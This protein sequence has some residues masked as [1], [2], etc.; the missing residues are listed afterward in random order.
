MAE[1]VLY[2]L[3][4]LQLAI[5]GG[6]FLWGAPHVRRSQVAAPAPPGPFPPVTVIV[7]VTGDAPL[8]RRCL[9][10]LLTNDYPDF[11]VIFVTRDE[12]DPAVAVIGEL[13]ARH[14][15]GRHVV[16]GPARRCG[17]KNHN[18]LAG[19]AAADPATDILVFC[20]ATHVAPPGFLGRL[21]R[22]LAAGEAVL[23]TGFHRIIPQDYRVG[24]LGMLMIV[25]CLHLLHGNRFI[26]QPWGGAT[27]I[28]RRVFQD[29]GVARVWAENI[30][31]DVSMAM[32]L[33]KDGIRV[34]AVGEAILETPLAG[35][36]VAHWA[37]WLVRQLLYL[38]FCAP[39]LWLGALVVV[40]ALVVPPLW[41]LGA[42]LG[43][44]GGWVSPGTA[45]PGWLYLLVLTALGA[46]YRTLAP[47][48]I[49]WPR[50]LLAYYATLMVLPWCYLRTWGTDIMA[51]RGIS[52][53]VGRG[54][55]VQEVIGNP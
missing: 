42:C 10:S 11:Q 30:V 41:A 49:P 50:W 7:P 13:I 29:H 27:A 45:L 43:G 53:R 1:L 51:W 35:E 15:R 24:T 12:S 3:M 38:K 28:V 19:I 54:G 25:L 37:D 21:V 46:V 16:S 52:Y 17:Q 44:L 18:L 47:F 20:D 36:T 5:L 26:V 2:G 48:G 6:L 55:K 34:K 9:E 39:A 22:P 14:A 31:D 4:G 40:A 32:H 33:V 8:T 23:V